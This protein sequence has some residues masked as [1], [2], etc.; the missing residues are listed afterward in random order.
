[1]KVHYKDITLQVLSAL[2][3]AKELMVDKRMDSGRKYCISEEEEALD[4]IALLI[5]DDKVKIIKRK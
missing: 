4:K 3:D 5:V 2:F 1:M